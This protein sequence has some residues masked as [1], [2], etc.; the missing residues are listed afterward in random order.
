[1]PAKVTLDEWLDE[2]LRAA[3]ID[4]EAATAANYRDALRPARLRLG[5]RALQKLT[6]SDIDELV[7]WMLPG[8]G[9][10]DVPIIR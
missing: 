8:D 6:E 1:M 7:S 3:T 10:G 5:S 9:D 4:V 2:W